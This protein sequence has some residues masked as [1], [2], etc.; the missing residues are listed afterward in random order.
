MMRY[1][2]ENFSLREEVRVLRAMESVKS[3]QEMAEQCTAELEASFQTQLEDSKP[4]K[5]NG[6]KVAVCSAILEYVVV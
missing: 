3:A 2:A 4:N 5:D 1:A 6:G